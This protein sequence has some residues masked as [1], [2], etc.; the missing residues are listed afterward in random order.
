MRHRLFDVTKWLRP[1]YSRATWAAV[2]FVR[3]SIVRECLCCNWL[4]SG[5]LRHSSKPAVG[6]VGQLC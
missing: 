5:K 1:M 4:C 3:D 6:R 2:I